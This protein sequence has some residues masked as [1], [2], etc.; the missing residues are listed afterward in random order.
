MAAAAPSNAPT[1]LRRRALA[2]RA[3]TA[4]F[5]AALGVSLLLAVP[6]QRPVLREIRHTNPAWITAAVGLEQ[7]FA[8]DILIRLPSDGF[9]L[10]SEEI[11]L[12]IRVFLP[13]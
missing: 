1:A 5:L 12:W 2:Q 13:C 10:G 11:L 4:G 7:R 8:A 6:A 3:G 9:V